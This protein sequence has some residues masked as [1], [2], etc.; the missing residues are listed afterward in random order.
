MSGVFVDT[1]ILVYARDSSEPRK[2][3]VAAAW[4]TRLWKSRRG[5][6]SFQVLQE[7]YVTV[8][9]KLDS[10][11]DPLTARGEVRALMKWRPQAIDREV[12]EVAWRVQDSH[13]LSWWDALIVAAAEASSCEFLLTEDLQDRQKI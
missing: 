13:R 1:N 6:L 4:M 2:Q 11:L 3:E 7:Y 9:H 8:T 5:R 12:L 10:R